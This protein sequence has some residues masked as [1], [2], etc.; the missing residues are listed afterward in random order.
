MMMEA[1]K[2]MI[3]DQYLLMHMWA[4]ATKTAMYMQNRSPQKLL[5]NKTLVEMFSGEK[6]EFGHLRIFG[7][8][9]CV[10][11]P[12]EKRTKLDQSKIMA[13]LLV[14]VTHRKHTGYIFPITKS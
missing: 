14:I 13:Y 10:H 3:H 11:V 9:V 8:P 5:E 6:Q 1:M 12:K 7:C 2:V 4:E